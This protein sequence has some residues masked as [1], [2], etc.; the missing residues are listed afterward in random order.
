[1]L[2]YLLVQSSTMQR[3]YNLLCNCFEHENIIK[4]IHLINNYVLKL[5][6]FSVLVHCKYLQLSYNQIAA[7]GR[8]TTVIPLFRPLV[9]GPKFIVDIG[10]KEKYRIQ[11]SLRS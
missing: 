10:I 1:M 3:T 9:V 8:T 2:I 4:T 7:Y 6:T 5:Q 11:Y